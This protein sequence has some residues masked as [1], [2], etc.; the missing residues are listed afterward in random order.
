MYPRFLVGVE[1]ELQISHNH[2]VKIFRKVGLFMGQRYRRMEDQNPEPGSACSLGF[3]EKKDF[4]LKLKRFPK[5]SK[6]GHVV[7][8]L[9]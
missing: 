5:L 2:V 8:K 1:A 7:S 4:S 9:V 6:L 3:A